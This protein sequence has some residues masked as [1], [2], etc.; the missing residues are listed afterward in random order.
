MYKVCL[1]SLL[2]PTAFFLSPH[3]YVSIWSAQSFRELYWMRLCPSQVACRLNTIKK[4]YTI[5]VENVSWEIQSSVQWPQDYCI[6]TSFSLIF[7]KLSEIQIKLLQTSV[8]LGKFYFIYKNCSVNRC[9]S[10]SW[11]SVH[12]N[13]NNFSLEGQGPF[14]CSKGEP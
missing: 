6:V 5:V 8:K 14:A 4:S 13:S 9:M 3:D 7:Q 11:V 12:S 2:L 10:F 1:V